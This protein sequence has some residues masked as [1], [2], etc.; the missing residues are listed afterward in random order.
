MRAVSAAQRGGDPEKPKTEAE[1][2]EK[3]F[4]M[5]VNRL[6]VGLDGDRVKVDFGK[7]SK[8]ALKAEADWEKWVAA[9]TQ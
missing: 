5:S 4:L 9:A 6:A 2:A 3:D 1:K 7:V 8:A